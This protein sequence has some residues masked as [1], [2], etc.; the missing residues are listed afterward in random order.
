VTRTPED[1]LTEIRGVRVE[2]SK[3]PNALYEAELKAERAEDAAQL[4]LDKALLLAEGSIP[5]KQAQARV[6]SQEI[7]DEAFIA[8]AE[9]NRVKTKTRG[10]ESA[11]MSLQSELKWMREEG[12]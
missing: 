6:Q 8:R 3:A 7:R 5:E 10:L 11:L 4:A 9:L 1:V 2:L 12:A